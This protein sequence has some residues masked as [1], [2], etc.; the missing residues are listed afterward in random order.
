MIRIVSHSSA[1]LLAA[2][3]GS[4]VALLA[5]TIPYFGVT[6]F[7]ILL[8]VYFAWRLS[9]RVA[10]TLPLAKPDVGKFRSNS[11]KRVLRTIIESFSAILLAYLV[12]VLL[13][14]W[15][16]YYLANIVALGAVGIQVLS[17]LESESSCNEKP[18]AKILQRY[19]IDKTERHTGIDLSLLK[20]KP[21]NTPPSHGTNQ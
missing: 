13:L 8:D 17:I 9:R 16:H 12:D 11:A 10:M 15:N 20:N 21:S 1:K 18:W 7:A 19:L 3:I 5:P 4:G 14:P 2:A 6:L